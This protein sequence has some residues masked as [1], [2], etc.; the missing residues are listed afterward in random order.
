MKTNLLKIKNMKKF[1]EWLEM[2]GYGTQV[3]IFQ[4]MSVELIERIFKHQADIHTRDIWCYK[5]GYGVVSYER[6]SHAQR[7][8]N[9]I[10][11]RNE[12]RNNDK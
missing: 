6:Y 7:L 1:C 9:Y 4:G 3:P 2:S 11:N 5:N 10:L 8:I 12:R